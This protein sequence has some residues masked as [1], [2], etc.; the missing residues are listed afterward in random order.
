MTLLEND[1]KATDRAYI[2]LQKDLFWLEPPDLAR[3][4]VEELYSVSR[5]VLDKKFKEQCKHDFNACYAEMYFAST[6]IDRVNFDVDHP[7]DKGLD[8]FLKN[9]RCWVDVTTAT[10]GAD[11]HPNSLA[12]QEL[13]VVQSYPE[14]KVILRLSNAFTSKAAKIKADI[15]KNLIQDDQPIIICIS[16]GGMKE[17][18]PMYAVGGYPQIIK[19]LLPVGDLVLWMDVNTRKIK[20]REYKYR[21]NV[22]KISIAG[23]A[24]IDTEFFLYEEYSYISAVVYSYANAGNP[25]NRNKWGCDF[26]TVHNPKARNPLPAGFIKCGQEYCVTTSMESFTMEPVIDHESSR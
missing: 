19:A 15:K 25:I 13:G 10:D 4:H 8:F 12:S 11:G 9:L 21:Q 16:G 1:P 2:N 24:L 23:E 22:K 6:F 18:F 3:K 26:F 17:G 20:S 7:S 14:D 5:H